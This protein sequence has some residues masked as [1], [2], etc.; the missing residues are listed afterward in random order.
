MGRL[1]GYREWRFGRTSAHSVST[2]SFSSC[3]AEAGK[4]ASPNRFGRLVRICDDASS[5]L[6]AMPAMVS[7]L[8]VQ[9]SHYTNV[10]ADILNLSFVITL[11]AVRGA[12]ISSPSTNLYVRS[13]IS[14]RPAVTP[15]C[16]PH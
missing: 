9:L 1:Q 10:F 4:N 14:A 8:H 5:T 12:H 11:R 2:L 7:K 16:C 13:R 3:L 15:G 6:A